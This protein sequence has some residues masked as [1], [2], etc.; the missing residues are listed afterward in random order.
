MNFLKRYILPRLI[1]YFVV[2]FIGITIVFL[3]PRFTPLDPVVS[4]MNRMTSYGSMYLDPQ[5]LEK[6]RE[7]MMELYGLKGSVWEQYIKFWGR[8]FK[9]DFG[10]SLSIFPT[11]VISIIRDS[12][13]WTAGLLIIAALLSWIIGNILGGLA[14][15]YSEKRWSKILSVVAMSI[16]PIPYYIM[17]LIL[18]ILFAYIFPFFPIVGGYSIGMKPSFSISFI[19]NLIKHAFLPALALI[20][21]GIGWWFLSMRSLTSTVKA[22][23]YVI[24]AEVMGIPRRKILFQY[25]MKNSL[26]PQI[27]NLA[28][29]IG[30][31]FSG[32]LV[33]ES[34]FSYPGLGQVLYMA[35]NNGD[36]NLMMGIAVFSIVGISTTALLIDLLYPLFDPRV[37][38]R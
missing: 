9:G 22:E 29:Q 27:T 5:A 24:Y 17:A 37:R 30:G 20:I 18:I 19:L 35:I 36:F 38:Y 21:V 6:L 26:L 3:V 33:T 34:V 14:G 25:V 11:P 8:L 23:D 28:L 10:P 32:S 7:T 15:Y 2:I 1:Q 31:I 16:Y 4:V 13:P 12:L